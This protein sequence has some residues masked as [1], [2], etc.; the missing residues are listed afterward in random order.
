MPTDETLTSFENTLI[1]AARIAIK[2]N[3]GELST[4]DVQRIYRIQIERPANLEPLSRLSDQ[5][6]RLRHEYLTG[7]QGSLADPGPDGAQAA[8]IAICLHEAERFQ[9]NDPTTWAAAIAE[10][11]GHAVVKDL[12]DSP[13]P[14]GDQI[15][16]L[17]ERAGLRQSTGN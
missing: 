13:A 3:D 6:S 15:R 17:A 10:L 14:T 1:A 9:R 7:L 2:R 8:Y 11:N 12:F 4:S 16:S 5:L